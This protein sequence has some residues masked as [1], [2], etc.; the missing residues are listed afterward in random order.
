MQILS[1]LAY[2]M[3]INDDKVRLGPISTNTSANNSDKN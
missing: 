3:L 2:N 1:Q